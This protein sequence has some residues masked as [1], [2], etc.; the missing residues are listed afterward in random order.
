MET[1][2]SDK[3]SDKTDMRQ[4]CEAGIMGQSCE[5]GI[6]LAVI[7]S[8]ENRAGL[9]YQC[10]GTWIFSTVTYEASTTLRSE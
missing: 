6:N 2:L 5:A 8:Y 3:S 10:T 7:R 4:S 9:K 1:T